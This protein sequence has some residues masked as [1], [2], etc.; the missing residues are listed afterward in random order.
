MTVA[1]MAKI[2]SD[3]SITKREKVLYELGDSSLKEVETITLESGEI[4]KCWI[5]KEGEKT[6]ILNTKPSWIK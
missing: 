2:E 4:S 5:L 1:G 6:T 3:G